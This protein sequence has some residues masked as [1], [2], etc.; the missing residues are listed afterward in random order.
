MTSGSDSED[1][2]I[3]NESPIE[4]ASEAYPMRSDSGQIEPRPSITV[5][6]KR[7]R[8]N[9]AP[10]S[11]EYSRTHPSPPYIAPESGVVSEARRR[12][13]SRRRFSSR[14]FRR[15]L[16][17]VMFFIIQAVFIVLLVFLWMKIEA[18]V[19]E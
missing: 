18:K 9:I 14:G 2:E 4:A 6:R 5:R 8:R 3:S 7:R 16:R 19:N 10:F 1:L 17:T 15:V 13:R 12:R 11:S